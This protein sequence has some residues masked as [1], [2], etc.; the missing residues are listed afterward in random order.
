MK[1]LTILMATAILALT[2]PLCAA[3]IVSDTSGASSSRFQFFWGQSFTTLTGGPWTD[4]TF[5]FYDLTGTPYAAGT[6]YIFAAA[7][8]GT[9]AN[10][11]NGGALA[12]SAPA[13][14]SVYAF[15]PQFSLKSD[16]QYFFYEDAAMR[17]LGGGTANVGGTS[18]FTQFGT[19][20]FA[21]AGGHNANF[22]VSGNVAAVP[23]PASWAMMIGGFG[24]VGGS[25]RRRRRKTT[26]S[27]A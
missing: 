20:A 7:Y 6:G 14:G 3:T 13:N 18:V 1:R 11:A 25:M 12:V 5:N 26:V 8:T 2:S 19:G 24:M 22:R 16:T 17:L 23:E 10:L 27:F 4:I 15:S 9:P 21:S